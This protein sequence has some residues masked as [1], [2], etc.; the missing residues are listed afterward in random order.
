MRVV[1]HGHDRDERGFFVEG[2]RQL[3]LCIFGAPREAKRYLRADL[4]GRY[5]SARDLRDG[6]EI[7]RLYPR[8]IAA[9]ETVS[10]G[11]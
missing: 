10:P 7:R 4:G 8:P 3:C 2:E 1:V 9:Q 11:I 5:T 6:V